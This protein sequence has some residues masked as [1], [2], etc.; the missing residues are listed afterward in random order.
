MRC[1]CAVHRELEIAILRRDSRQSR[2][3]TPWSAQY[4]FHLFCAVFQDRSLLLR[5][6][7]SR[8]DMSW[9]SFWVVWAF[10]ERSSFRCRSRMPS[11][12]QRLVRPSVHAE[13]SLSRSVVESVVRWLMGFPASGVEK[14]GSRVGVDSVRVENKCCLPCPELGP[15]LPFDFTSLVRFQPGGFQCLMCAF[16]CSQ[17]LAGRRLA[18]ETTLS[19]D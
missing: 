2:F 13:E 16:V 10:C 18:P 3:L 19:H 1:S 14:R 7:R 11:C 5:R 8:L 15:S 17:Y 12:G 9:I 6:L 4:P